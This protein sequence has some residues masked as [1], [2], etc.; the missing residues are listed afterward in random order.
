MPSE[1]AQRTT[2]TRSLNYFSVFRIDC[3]VPDTVSLLGL[4]SCILGS[5]TNYGQVIFVRRKCYGL[6]CM[7]R[8]KH[9]CC[10]PPCRLGVFSDILSVH[11]M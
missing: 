10:D 6:P 5:V 2:K 11:D 8:I 1:S 4:F 7:F 3:R 9:V